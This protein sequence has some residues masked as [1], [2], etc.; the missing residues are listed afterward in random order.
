[1]IRAWKPPSVIRPKQ[2][3]Y[4]GRGKGCLQMYGELLKFNRMSES[5]GKFAELTLRLR[6]PLFLNLGWVA[7]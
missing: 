2:T 7:V 1:M 4:N 6:R 5:N 3:R